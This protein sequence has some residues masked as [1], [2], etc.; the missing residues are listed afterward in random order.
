M[1]KRPFCIFSSKEDNERRWK[2]RHPREAARQM[3]A[4]RFRDEKRERSVPDP[5]KNP[6]LRRDLFL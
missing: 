5:R 1:R 4:R 3:T 2:K 6:K